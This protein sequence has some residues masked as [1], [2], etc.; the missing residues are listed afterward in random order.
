MKLPVALASSG[1]HNDNIL[2]AQTFPREMINVFSHIVTVN[3]QEASVNRSRDLSSNQ[4]QL[5]HGDSSGILMARPLN[6]RGK[7]ENENQ[8]FAQNHAFAIA[9]LVEEGSNVYQPPA[10]TISIPGTRSCGRK[11]ITSR[12]RRARIT[13]GIK[14]LQD[15]LPNSVEVIS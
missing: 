7:W 2:M 8:I 9:E 4:H 6:P 11:A 5:L 13:E 12:V 1:F 10:V 15:I 14:A 3:A